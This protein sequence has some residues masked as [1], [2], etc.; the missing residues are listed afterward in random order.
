MLFFSFIGEEEKEEVKDAV[1]DEP[2]VEDE[3]K[4]EDSPQEEESF[5]DEQEETNDEEVSD[6]QEGKEAEDEE[7]QDVQEEDQEQGI[8]C[9]SSFF[10]MSIWEL[11]IT[12]SSLF[13]NYPGLGIKA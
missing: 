5:E 1:A 4:V 6:E 8:L 7:S 2:K 3:Q 13:N 11:E 10:G 9:N 12:Y